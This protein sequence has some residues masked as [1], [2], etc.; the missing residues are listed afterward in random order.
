MSGT[1]T[2]NANTSIEAL[3]DD[4]QMLKQMVLT[5]LGQIDDLHGQLHYLKRQLFGRRSEKLDPN[6]RLLFENLYEEVQGK[7][8][9]QQQ[10]RH[11]EKC[12]SR[13]PSSRRQHPGRKPLPADL[14]REDIVI[15]PDAAEMTCSAC[16]S[17]KDPI[18]R[19]VTEKLE[20]RPASFFVK[21]YIRP[22]YACRQC[23][24]DVAIGDLPAMA[25][26][27]GLCGEGLLAHIITSKYCDH[28]PLNRLEG[29]LQRHGVD[30]SVSTMCDQV[31]RCAELLAPLVQRMHQR[32]LSSPK[33]NTD[34]T[35]I[36][37]QSSS[38]KGSTYTGY[39]WAYISAAREVVFDFTPTRSREGPLRM[40]K[41]Y[42]GKVQADAYSGY[43]ALFRQPGIVEVGCHAHAR[44]K[45]EYALDSDPVRSARLL[46][47]WSRLYEMESR[48]KKE[49]YDAARL[50]ALRQQESK[51]ILVEMHALLETYR[52]EALPKSPLGQ[53]LTYALNQWVALERYTEDPILE[54]DNNLAE[55][56]LRMVVIGRK[57]Y[58]FAGSEA[59]A[60]RAA[61]IY[62]LVAT[63]K[64]H[65]VDPFAYFRDVLGRISTHPA[66][67]IDELLPSQWKTAVIQPNDAAA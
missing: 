46:A 61:I 57:N 60:R 26:D 6:Q 1:T 36:P 42:Q 56:V 14:P 13:N 21:Q 32:L 41:D 45:A 15:E 38:R 8:E 50:L 65:G 7:I 19:E 37:V 52:R 51:P 33:I 43:D 34:D 64:L 40:L 22:K 47:L 48:A 62:S 39:L 53:A 18:G 4:V 55:R 25:V 3:P 49:H 29:M 54:M 16:G 63:C 2:I 27:K 44:R 31:G 10:P 23:Q 58:L 17:V 12:S 11:E 24:G 66:A 9:A 20:Y 67:R 59:G 5:L 28:A 35:G 30:L